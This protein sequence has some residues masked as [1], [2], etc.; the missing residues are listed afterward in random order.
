MSGNFDRLSVATG[1]ALLWVAASVPAAAQ[2]AEQLLDFSLEELLDVQVR[3]ASRIPTNPL[4]AASSVKVI[5]EAVWQRRGARNV[6]D[7]LAT[8]PG[9]AIAP[10]LGGADAFA[11]RG[12]TRGTSLLGVLL[13]W[14][15]VP[16][17]DLFRGAPTL[18]VPS[19]NLGAIDEIQLIEGPGSALYGSDAFHGV[20]ALN[21]FNSATDQRQVR[22]GVR[23][24]GF[25]A[26]DARLS[27]SLGARAR[28]SLAVT[29]DG[30]PDQ[31]LDFQYADPMTGALRSGERGNE[32]G[33]QALSFKV[34]G[35]ADAGVAWHGG[36]LLHHYDGER[37]QGFGTRLAETR[38]VGGIETDLYIVNGGMRQQRT[39]DAAIEVSGYAWRSDSVLRAARTAFDFESANSQNRYGVHATYEK[40]VL[41]VNT[42]LAFV[43][44]IE[45]LAIDK[46]RTRNF[47]SSG[48][49]TLDT[50]NP[51]EGADRRIYS[52][53]FE[54]NTH[55]AG[56]R[57][58]V[59]YGAR[60]DDYSDF[61]S[62]A[63]PRI[64]LIWHPR[65]NNSVKLLYGT[66]FRA[67][68]AND[69]SGTPGLIQNNPN[70]QPEDIDT[71]ELV[72]MHQAERWFTQA[73]VFRSDWHDGIVSVANTGG[74]AP[75]VFTNLEEN[76]AHGV[77]WD[78][79]WQAEPWLLNVGASWVRSE[80]QTLDVGYDA[81]PRYVVDAQVGYH[82]APWRTRFHL[83][84]HLQIDTDDVFPASAGIPATRL[85]QYSRIDIGAIHTLST[86]WNLMLFVRNL[87]DR[88]NFL[89]SGAGSRG[90][91]P[92][93]S[94][95]FGAE[96]RF[97]F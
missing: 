13:S 45:Q 43:L 38:D 12:Y 81:F 34:R 59:V 97:T 76:R 1:A 11:I 66:A 8:V 23:S 95:T 36:A 68:T 44:G 64:G 10:G 93:E 65:E 80:N 40:G 2:N 56:E 35:E 9:V 73:S 70:L 48:A 74:S 29:A 91:I 72:F 19:L 18:N 89:P 69:I 55:W 6:S 17:N 84:Q 52:L 51:A 49:I 15:G 21:A 37:F 53:T 82:H 77:T 42:Q 39:N 61:G 58:R 86:R 87:S 50:P 5:P 3:V 90:G 31:G 62:Q 54:G 24:N 25:F 20:V 28:A 7:V 63:S 71:L 85:P 78:F 16:L 67:P 32:Y 47:D 14:D 79:N 88:D 96:A 27:A 60:F 92:D 4:N 83:T 46:A 57:W 22:G 75:F 41:D 94:R 26:T 33:A 30:Q